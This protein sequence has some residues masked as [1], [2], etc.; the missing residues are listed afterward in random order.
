[1]EESNSYAFETTF[2]VDFKFHCLQQ[3]NDGKQCNGK[4][5]SNQHVLVH[6]DHQNWGLPWPISRGWQQMDYVPHW[7]QSKASVCP[8]GFKVSFHVSSSLTIYNTD[9]PN[10]CDSSSSLESNWSIRCRRSLHS[11]PN[12]HQQYISTR[13]RRCMQIE[14]TS[15]GEG[16]GPW[17][18]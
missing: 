8:K 9:L 7:G 6:E 3:K 1:M 12:S 11:S 10:S 15:W 2:Q 16:G 13:G 17:T 14:C 4:R 5:L 18:W